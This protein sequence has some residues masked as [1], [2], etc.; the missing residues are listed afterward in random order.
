[1]ALTGEELT[2]EVQALLGRTNDTVLCTDARITRWLNEAQDEIA[3]ECP[4]LL[5]LAFDV[6][7]SHTCVTTSVSYAIGDLS[8]NDPTAAAACHI[9]DVFY[10]DG[11]N[12]YRLKYTHLDVFDEQ[13]VDI[14][15]TDY[16]R[17]RPYRWTRRGQN[18]DM[19]PLTDSGYSGD[20]LRFTG[21]RY[22]EDFTTNDSG[23]SDLSKADDGLIMYAVARGWQAIGKEEKKILWDSDFSRWL[24]D[25][26]EKND[27][28]HGWPGNLYD[29][30]ID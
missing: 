8:V 25:Y 22:C 7:E 14:T 21:T 16:L 11:Q 17:E 23:A 24:N 12:S 5:C 3:E 27:T 2:D 19:Y 9:H 1:M 28:I 26:R 10:M 29:D 30:N 20:G 4:D 18:I 6:T 13:Y 15:H